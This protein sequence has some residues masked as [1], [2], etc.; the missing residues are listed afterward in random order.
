MLSLRKATTIIAI[1]FVLSACA[2]SGSKDVAL[3][4]GPAT[5]LLVPNLSE[6]LHYSSLGTTIL[7][8][9]DDKARI[10]GWSFNQSISEPFVSLLSA[11]GRFNVSLEESS[12]SIAGILS[13]S[14][15]RDSLSDE[16]IKSLAPKLR[17]LTDA[18]YI[19]YLESYRTTDPF[20]GSLMTLEGTGYY[21]RS[22]LGIKRKVAYS[23]VKTTLI[24]VQKAEIIAKSKIPDYIDRPDNMWF[25]ESAFPSKV[26]SEKNRATIDKLLEKHANRIYEKMGFR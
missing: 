6:K 1:A 25:E 4:E 24:D 5:L 19:L 18:R 7:Q 20:M 12:S 9:W 21:Q 14:D 17:E 16:K 10:E 22:F 8:Q 23:L 13:S 26:A 11:D 3:I 15:P 2:V